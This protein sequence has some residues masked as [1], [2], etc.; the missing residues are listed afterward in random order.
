M[1]DRQVIRARCVRVGVVM[2][3]LACAMPASAQSASS[4]WRWTVVPY[5]W[6]AGVG[7]TIGV[8]DLTVST[9]LSPGDLLSHL[10]FSASGIVEGGYSIWSAQLDAFYVS[11]SDSRV[12]AIRGDTGSFDLGVKLTMLQPT[13]HWMITQGSWGS[14]DVLGG[15]RYWHLSLSTTTQFN[16]RQRNRSAST[17]VW[18]GIGGLR[19]ITRPAD[20]WRVIADGNIGAGASKFAWQVQGWA[21]YDIATYWAVTA[22]YRYLHSE[23]NRPNS[24]FDG[25][26]SGFVV[27][28]AYRQ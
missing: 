9:S 17:N 7:S 21:A 2:S 4:Q 12:T 11:L 14:V 22:G 25:R 18:D 10:D 3:L 6:L 28:V 27:G 1:K 8:R 24:S 26:L 13:A 19:A 23:F 16:S 5:G 20:R 15:A